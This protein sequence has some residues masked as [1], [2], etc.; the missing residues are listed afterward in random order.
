MVQ[1]DLVRDK[2]RRLRETAAALATCLPSEA[3]ALES[4][5]DARDLVAF[6]VYLALQEAVDLC[7]HIIADQGWGP[8]PNLRDHFV[9]LG[10]KGVI[11]KGIARTFSEGMKLRN[12]IGHAYAVVDPAKLRPQAFAEAA[13]CLR[14]ASCL[15]GEAPLRRR[16]PR[17]SA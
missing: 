11:D 10:D 6:R 7:A 3:S 17:G 2:I 8:A 9:L 4:D 14:Q 12:L 15:T 13:P 16:C 5:R 1:V